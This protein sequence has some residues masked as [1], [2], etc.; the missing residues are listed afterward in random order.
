VAKRTEG[1]IDVQIFPAGALGNERE[2]IEGAQIGTVD[3]IVTSSAATGPF[4]RQMR[5]LDTPFLFR[6]L[7]HAR[8][9]LDSEIGDD[10]LARCPRPGWSGWPGATSAFATCRRNCRLTR[11]RPCK[12]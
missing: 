4:I 11:L 9:V 1:R 7:G 2:V 12:V 3:M 8:A 6:D 10:C 5:F